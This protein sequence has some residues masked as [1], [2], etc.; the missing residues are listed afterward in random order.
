MKTLEDLPN[1]W[2]KIEEAHGD[3]FT[4]QT[5]KDNFIKDFAFQLEREELKPTTHQ[6]QQFLNP[7]PTPNEDENLVDQKLTKDC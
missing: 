7:V 4:W 1:K 2:Y 3:M 5:L 6:I